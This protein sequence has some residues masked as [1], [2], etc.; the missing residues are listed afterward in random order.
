MSNSPAEMVTHVPTSTHRPSSPQNPPE[1]SS[2]G[3]GSPH[4]YRM[5]PSDAR[6]L[7]RADLVGWV[8]EGLETFLVGPLG[9]VARDAEV[10]EVLDL[11]GLVLHPARR[12]GTWAPAGE[13][14]G[15]LTIVDPSLV[16]MLTSPR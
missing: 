1:Q 16:P 8:G 11:D 14:G 2:G 7:S 12:A 10:L 4:T 6:A 3:Q 5:R 13:H 15:L 9:S